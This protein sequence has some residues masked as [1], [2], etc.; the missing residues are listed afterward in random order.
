MSI[1]EWVLCSSK[2]V[3]IFV[4][5]DVRPQG[6]GALG[7]R[8]T[9]SQPALFH[10]ILTLTLLIVHPPLPRSGPSAGLEVEK[11]TLGQS[12]NANP[13]LPGSQTQSHPSVL[14]GRGAEL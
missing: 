14:W 4:S 5:G 2:L 3:E 11:A 12:Q 13:D 9:A 10:L 6:P 1:L 7:V 8:S